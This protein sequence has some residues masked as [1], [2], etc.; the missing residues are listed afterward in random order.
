M[1][2]KAMH[3]AFIKPKNVFFY[4]IYLNNGYGDVG[5]AMATT[6]QKCYSLSF[7]KLNVQRFFVRYCWIMFWQR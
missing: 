2:R 3:S 5:N 4:F 7:Q 6:E 1:K